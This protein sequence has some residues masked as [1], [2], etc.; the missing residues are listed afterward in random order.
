M[1]ALAAMSIFEGAASSAARPPT[2]RKSGSS[3]TGSNA[4]A[5][6]G[7]PPRSTSGGQPQRPSCVAPFQPLFERVAAA[8]NDMHG[9]FRTL[10]QW[11]AIA[12][13]HVMHVRHLFQARGL[14]SMSLYVSSCLCMSLY[15]VYIYLSRML[16]FLCRLNLTSSLAHIRSPLSRTFFQ[17][18]RTCLDEAESLFSLNTMDALP[19]AWSV[20]PLPAA[21]D[22]VVNIHMDADSNLDAGANTPAQAYPLALPIASPHVAPTARFATM[23]VHD[24]LKA[25]LRRPNLFP[26]HAALTRV[27]PPN[28][29]SLHLCVKANIPRARV[30]FSLVLRAF[31]YI[32][33]ENSLR[34]LCMRNRNMFML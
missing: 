14:L 19:L 7:S 1:S 26:P 5:G 10:P 3:S 2:H 9:F 32:R 13:S 18:A 15:S 23:R 22:D 20:P 21:D 6:L 31:D 30:L 11:S 25:G 8:M 24:G 34:Q 12:P 28:W 33:T 17:L 27:P 29:A 16:H 4:T